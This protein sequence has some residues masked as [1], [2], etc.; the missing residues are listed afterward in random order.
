MSKQSELQEHMA[1]TIAEAIE[2]TLDPTTEPMA[3]DIA[4]SLIQHFGL[5][6]A[7]LSP[8]DAEQPGDQPAGHHRAMVIGWW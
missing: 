7:E 3:D 6:A 2:T 5:R 4:R 1:A 8:E